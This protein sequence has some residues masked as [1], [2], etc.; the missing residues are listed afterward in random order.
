MNNTCIYTPVFNSS[1]TLESTAYA[2]Q[3]HHIF[4]DNASTD[5]TVPYLRNKHYHVVQNTE[6]I[7]RI[8][9]W[10][11]C[12]NHFKDEQTAPYF[13]W[14]FSGDVLAPNYDSLIKKY[15]TQF[16]T[17]H[18]LVF[19]YDIYDGEKKSRWS[20]FKEPL[21]IDTETALK[22]VIERGNWFGSPIGHVISRNALNYSYALGTLPFVA[23]M[24]LCLDLAKNGP[25]AYIPESIGTFNMQHRHYYLETEQKLSSK[26]EEYQIRSLAAEYLNPSKVAKNTYQNQID[27]WFIKEVELYKKK[28]LP[29]P[30]R[31][32]E[33]T[34]K[35]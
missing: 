24:R 30:K 35:K 6:T 25:V 22:Y 20:Q 29:S 32:W 10:N 31:F 23:D 8:E 3:E 13:K 5:T 34:Q 18:L 27:T 26:M 14:L 11:R 33:R 7:S 19:E 15:T 4:V 12:L 28:H 2:Q 16:P 17:A 9:N 1:K 21:L